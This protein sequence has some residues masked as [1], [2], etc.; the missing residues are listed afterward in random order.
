MIYVLPRNLA[1]YSCIDVDR[2]Q[3]RLVLVTIIEHYNSNQ[4]IILIISHSP[5]S[6]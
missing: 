3:A 5:Y 2:A 1:L 6:L 4:E